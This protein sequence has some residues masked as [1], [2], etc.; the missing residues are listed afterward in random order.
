MT[1][2]PAFTW[3]D[4]RDLRRREIE[5]A[6]FLLAYRNLDELP[7]SQGNDERMLW[8]DYRDAWIDIPTSA[9]A[10]LALADL[11]LPSPPVYS[12]GTGFTP[13]DPYLDDLAE[14]A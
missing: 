11:E 8:E 6:D 5:Q 4:L 7:D 1:L 2:P 14:A 10:G 9:R 13:A 3:E 12:G